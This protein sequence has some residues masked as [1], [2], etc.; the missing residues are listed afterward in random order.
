MCGECVCVC[1][2]YFGG[3]NLKSGNTTRLAA[4]EMPRNIQ[5]SFTLE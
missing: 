2:A 3:E 1:F 4:R 5:E